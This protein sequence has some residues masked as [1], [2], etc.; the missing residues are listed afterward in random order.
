[1]KH[2][3][4][5]TLFAFLLSAPILVGAQD[6]ETNQ[7][8]ARIEL[9]AIQSLTLSDEQLLKGDAS[10]KPVT[11]SGQLRIAQG[12][13][14]LPTVIMIHGSGGISANIDL[15]S[16]EFNQMG[17][18]TFVVDGFTGRGL[19]TV[20]TD[21]ALL[22]RLNLM[23]D[24]YRALEVL[25]K[26]PQVDRAR[27]VL[28]GFSRGGQATLYASLRRFHQTWNKSG[29]DF[30]AYIPF[31]PDCMTTYLSDT[32][33]VNRPIRIFHGSVDDYDPVAPC[34]AYV[35]RLRS[36][37]HDIE[38]TEYANAAHGFDNPLNASPP[39]AAKDSQTVRR[40][41]IREEP[42]GTLINAAT[43]Q[44]FTYKDSC[45]ERGPHLG[46]DASAAHAARQAVRQFLRTVVK[47]N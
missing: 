32:D 30:A 25:A 17:I 29:V 7:L 20:N 16:T 42:M 19:T 12:S 44:P 26:H 3:G 22:G 46:Y 5:V 6:S 37:G 36:G 27:I 13:A 21:Q 14:R 45:V 38:L 34:K 10:G 24:G 1:M 47:L 28:M 18:S 23:L 31:Y 2:Q 39:T 9:H 41:T 33:V 35:Q 11:V 15:W 8:A 40:C 43:K 4:I